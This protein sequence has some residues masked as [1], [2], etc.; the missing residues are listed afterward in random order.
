MIT[1]LNLLIANVYVVRGKRTV[2]VDT[3]A[4]GSAPRILRALARHGISRDDISL[5]LL[6]HAHS[7]HAGSAGALRDAL[8]APVAV[9]RDDVAML[10]RGD[11]GR[12]VT[13]GLEAAMSK[14][15]V[16]RPFPGITPDILLDTYTDL[17]QFGLDARL[18]HTPGHSPGSVSLVFGNGEA[19]VGDILRGGLM[20][21]VLFSGRPAYPYFLYSRDDMQTLHGSVARVL[22]AGATRLYTGH[23]GALSRAA[24]ERW[25]AAQRQPAWAGE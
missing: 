18:L 3:G 23:G 14:P 11:N 10:E 6:T 20:G 1:K 2:I 8:H 7:D 15:F 21:G 17:S 25:L 24:A 19:I 5:I 9:H 4:P 12:F 16:D 22:D 13:M